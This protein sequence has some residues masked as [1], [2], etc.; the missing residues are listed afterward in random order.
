[1]LAACLLG[2]A[3]RAP[4]EN[5]PLT[6]EQRAFADRYVDAVR[7]KD[8]TKLK[9]LVHPKSL[10]CIRPESAAFFDDV[11][12]RRLRDGA[13]GP[14]RA[15]A[16]PIPPGDPL[17]MEGDLTYPVRPTQWIQIDLDPD[18]TSSVTFLMQVAVARGTWFEVL[19]CPTPATLA[20]FRDKKIQDGKDA[21]RAGDLLAGLRD[22][23]LAELK[24][25]V[26]AGRTA[27]A[28]MRYSKASGEST[29][30]ARHLI[31]LLE[32]QR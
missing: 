21:Q 5:V 1:M 27:T 28:I 8:V 17:L 2:V 10:E 9:A 24:E 25:L 18:A 12:A 19:P 15:S 29:G 3:A 7:A 11:F 13:T 32:A 16:G 30:V 26:G 22:P 31:E 23:L 14:Y 4:A 20:K 6:A